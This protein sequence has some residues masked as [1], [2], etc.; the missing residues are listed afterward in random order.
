MKKII[1]SII[2]IILL[3]P[4]TYADDLTT[5][6]KAINIADLRLNQGITLI[7]IKSDNDFE[8]EACRLVE[9][10][11]SSL[12]SDKLFNEDCYNLSIYCLSRKHKRYALAVS[13]LKKAYDIEEYYKLKKW[14]KIRISLLDNKDF[15]EDNFDISKEISDF[16]KNVL[17]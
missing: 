7:D 9:F 15:I 5:I 3:I 6:E 14:I 17:R 11:L 12:N 10:A 8:N 13:V 2:L 16:R 1:I 4:A